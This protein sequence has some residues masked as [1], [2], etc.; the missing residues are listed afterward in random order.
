MVIH[1]HAW[2]VMKPAICYLTEQ[3][4]QEDDAFP[5]DPLNAMRENAITKTHLDAINGRLNASVSAALP[6]KLYTHNVDVDSINYAELQ[7]LEGEVKEFVMS[8][9]GSDPLVDALKKSCLAP[10]QLKLKIGAEVMFIKN[11]Y[12]AGYVNGTRGV[13]KT[14]DSR[15]E[16]VVEIYST[17]QRIPVSAMDWEV[18]ENGRVKAS[19]T[20]YPL[21]L[22]WAI[23]IHKSQGM[24]LDSAEIDL[25]KTFAYGMGYVALSRVRTLAGIRLVGFSPESL[26]VDPMVASKAR[27]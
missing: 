10:E 13:I 18:E 15:G 3:H 25:S 14:F 4:R 6:T 12:E 17:G 22:A 11:N 9:R 19:I 26:N 7:K 20:Q 5:R 2:K 8:G 24:S 16:P 27:Q 21:R 1:S 23:T